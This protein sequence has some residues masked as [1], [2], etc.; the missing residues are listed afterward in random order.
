M[1]FLQDL[2]TVE[3]MGRTTIDQLKLECKEY[4]CKVDSMYYSVT[5]GKLSNPDDIDPRDQILNKVKYKST[6]AKTKSDL[7]KNRL[8]LTLSDMEE[9]VKYY[10][11]DYKDIEVRNKFFQ[12]FI[13]F[14]QLFKKCN[15][16]N[17]EKEEMERLYNERNKTQILIEDDND[18][19][20]N[21][22]S[23]VEGNETGTS[24]IDKL[25][26]KLRDVEKSKNKNSKHT[27]SDDNSSSTNQNNNLSIRKKREKRNFRN[28]TKGKDTNY[29]TNNNDGKEQN[30]ETKP[31]LL[32]RAQTMLNN[33]QKI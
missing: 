22:K 24:K 9:L 3:D 11:E 29:T 7:L 25:L 4:C 20:A 26:T 16:E 27:I 5:R 14:I 6:R 15:K 12:Q 19:K 10:G 30:N 18:G 23:T 8:E 33:I 28:K 13:E 2:D 21:E 1:S 31:A 32:Q 17:M